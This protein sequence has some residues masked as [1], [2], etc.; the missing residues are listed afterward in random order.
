[1]L[2]DVSTVEMDVFHQ[3]AAIF[4]VENNMLFFS[5]R[6]AAFDHDTNRIRGTLR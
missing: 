5:R 3:R 2:N 1:M 4:T 6:Q